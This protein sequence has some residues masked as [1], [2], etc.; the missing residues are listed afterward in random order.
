MEARSSLFLPFKNLGL[1][2]IDEEHENSY[3]QQ[4]PSPR[5]HAR[6]SAII[7]SKITQI[8]NYTWILQPHQ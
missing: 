5:Y 1:I 8:K 7:L 3:K 4:E 6:D 2:I